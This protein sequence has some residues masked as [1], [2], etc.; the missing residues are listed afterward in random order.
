MDFAVVVLWVSMLTL[1]FKRV[2]V[3]KFQ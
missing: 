2:P 3:I 1:Q